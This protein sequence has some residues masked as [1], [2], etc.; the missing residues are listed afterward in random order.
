MNIKTKELRALRALA[1]QTLNM[2][3]QNYLDKLNAAHLKLDAL[4]YNQALQELQALI[5]GQD[6]VFQTMR[7]RAIQIYYRLQPEGERSLSAAR[8]LAE[9]ELAL[10]PAAADPESVEI[11]EADCELGL[12][13]ANKY[14]KT[15]VET[16]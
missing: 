10:V 6:P 2:G 5:G 14:L 3:L 13:L 7:L 11:L 1:Q 15:V 9:A 4:A 8:L 16:C 12:T